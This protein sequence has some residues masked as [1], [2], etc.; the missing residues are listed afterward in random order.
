MI[1]DILN[2]KDSANILFLGKSLNLNKDEI[3]KFL[4]KYNANAIFEYNNQHIDLI[5]LSS[6]IN[7]YEEQISY[8]L[9]D[10]GV[11]DI[12]LE[13]FESFFIDNL[14]PNALLM[15][16]KLSNN[17]SRVKRLLQSR[18]FNDDIY[19]KLFKL[20]NWNG[21]GLFDTDENRDVTISFIKRFFKPTTQ[22]NHT[23]IVHSPATLIEIALT[24]TNPNVLDAIFNMPKYKT[25]SR[26]QEEWKP[27]DLKEFVTVN[28]YIS[29][30]LIEKILALKSQRFNRLLAINSAINKEAQLKIY[31]SANQDIKKALSTNPNLDFKIF[32]ELLNEDLEVVKTLL[33]SQHITKEHL[34]LIDK[35]YLIY[36]ANNRNIQD[37]IKDL[38]G[39]NRELDIAISINPLL[40]SKILEELYIKYRDDIAINISLNPNTP[41]SILEEI[42]SKFR[43]K[44]TLY[45]AQNP[46][47]PEYII[48]ELFNINSREI[49]RYLAL[50]CNLKDEYL[51]YFKLDSELLRIMSQN[52][53]FL[54]KIKSKE[55]I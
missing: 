46:N 2:K 40:N 13:E 4:K 29:K 53:K 39:I 34:E 26:R 33:E 11:Q 17:Q 47:T 16:L 42:Y 48:D 8:T 45:I 55:P 18:A 6:I 12:K 7:P 52:S 27:R 36:L 3:S 32:K 14:K 38:I 35:N 41:A 25:N 31:K 15:S 19:L 44:T 51:D 43:D 5:I 10:M 49:N 20:Y 21:E 50:N 37:I 24:S 9:Y 22:L 54:D 23:D 28:P 1:K 30:S